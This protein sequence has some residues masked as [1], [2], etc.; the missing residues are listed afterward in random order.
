MTT[1]AVVPPPAT[2]VEPDTASGSIP[3][4]PAGRNKSDRA[5]AIIRG[6]PIMR[7]PKG[8]VCKIGDALMAVP[9]R[10]FADA[11]RE[12]WSIAY[13]DETVG[14]GT[15]ARAVD[16]IKADRTVPTTD[17]E[18]ASS[19]R[20]TSNGDGGDDRP[21]IVV[22]P[23]IEANADE[24]IPHL[25]NDGRTFQRACELVH[26]TMA[27]DE[28]ESKGARAPISKGS[29]VIRSTAIAT[30]TENASS[31][32]RWVKLNA[33]GEERHVL[34]PSPVVAAVHARGQWRGVPH[35]L[36][37]QESPFMRLD[38]T[39]V[40]TPGHDLESW[41][42]YAPNAEFPRVPEN[43]THEQSK[44][45]LATLVD[46]YGDFPFVSHAARMV[47][48]SVQL[49]LQARAA[50]DG[51]TPCHA[52]DASVKGGGKTLA[53]S[54]PVA[55]HSGRPPSLATFP[56]GRNGQEEL[57]KMLGAYALAG[58]S[59]VMFDNVPIGVPFGGAPLEKCITAADR[60][61]LRRLGVSETPEL[62]WRAVVIA[63][64]NNLAIADETARRTLVARIVPDVERPEERTGFK[65]PEIMKYVLEKRAELVVAGLTVLRGYVAAGMPDTGTMSLGSFE[66][67]SRLV[68]R[69][70]VWAGG[71]D[72][73]DAR[74]TVSCDTDESAATLHTIVHGLPRILGEHENGLTAG[75]ILDAL[76][77]APRADEPPDGWEGLRTALESATGTRTGTKPEPSKL[78]T[79]FRGHRDRKVD[80]KALVVLGQQAR[81]NRWGIK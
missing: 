47:P 30:L 58:V 57:E 63:T 21:V 54:I 78:G 11:L 18:P 13:P 8:L 36:A 76:Y 40:Q 9:S 59:S 17:R 48:I 74:V 51:P 22:T 42:F 79:Y 60:V 35:L 20:S 70:I 68:P 39:I 5:L 65:H 67:W 32:V 27:G 72:V 50:I 75:A 66:A 73:L 37:V 69:A 45:A 16:S 3:K 71:A 49:T 44:K 64:G 14:K 1:L 52:G 6:M 31:V 25:A 19:V 26:I 77:P 7:G 53:F 41:Y 38:G 33:E 61:S 15:I 81:A 55:I 28:D 43:P 62:P 24:L 4:A 2:D 34:P 10:A 12:E 80:G 23:D 56:N 46:L 29:P